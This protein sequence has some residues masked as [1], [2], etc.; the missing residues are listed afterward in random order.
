ML[1]IFIA[2]SHLE[3]CRVNCSPNYYNTIK[4]PG[5]TPVFIAPGVMNFDE[6]MW[7]A[8]AGEFN[9]TGINY[10]G[11]TKEWDAVANCPS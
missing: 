10:H 1:V 4:I 11:S 9:Q 2:T 6:R 3:Y 7:G 8:D 5:G